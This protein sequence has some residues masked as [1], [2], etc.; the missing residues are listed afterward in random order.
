MRIPMVQPAIAPL[1]LL[2]LGNGFEQMYTA[3]V[4]PQRWRHVNLGVSQLPK[5]KVAEPH[6]TRGAYYQ[7]RIRQVARIKVLA[8]HFFIN[9]EV[10]DAAILRG[11]MHHRAERVYQLAA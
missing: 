1:P 2:I 9:V 11:R 10:L 8:D 3:E 5:Q 6:L 4:G 7:I